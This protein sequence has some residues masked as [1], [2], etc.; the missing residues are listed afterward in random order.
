MQKTFLY[1]HHTSISYR[2]TGSGHPVVLLHGFGEDSHIWDKQID[3][4]KDHCLL[5]VP[6]LPGSGK[7]ALL[8]KPDTQ[9]NSPEPH[10]ISITDYAD[11]VYA[12]L[13]IEGIDKCCLLGHSMGGYITLAFAEKYPSKLSSF[14]LIH[15]TALADTEEK[16][17]NRQKAIDLM[18]QYGAGPFLKNTIPNLFAGSFKKAQPEMVEALIEASASFDTKACQQYYQAMMLRPDKTSVLKG[19]PLPVLFVIGTEDIAAP[20]NDL[21]PQ[22]HL[23]LISY[24]HVLENTGHMGMWEATEQ[25]NQYLL[26]FILLQQ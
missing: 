18:E 19:N 25:M 2:L 15:S 17:R 4:L 8:S 14:G 23:P 22:V 3:F 6:D 20:L 11:V 7:S 10:H 5:I 26:E 12:L 24:I 1:N 21:L 9:N 16:K 13:G